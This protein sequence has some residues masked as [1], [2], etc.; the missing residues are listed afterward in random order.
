MNLF[1]DRPAL[2]SWNPSQAKQSLTIATLLN[3]AIRLVLVILAISA[4]SYWHL[5]SQLAE[6]T[7]AKLLGYITER[8]QREEEIFILAEDN[9]S[10]LQ[11][12]FLQGLNSSSSQERPQ[13]FH[14]IFS[15]WRDGTTRNVVEGTNENEFNTEYYPTSFI[16][17]DV[18]LTLDLQQRMVLSYELVEKYGAGW[19]NRFL[20]TYISLPEGANTVLWPG[21]AWGINAD[22]NLDIPAEEWAYLGDRIHNPK[23]QTLWTGVYADPVTQDFMVSAETPIDD[24]RGRHLATIGHDI[25]LT[26]LLERTIADRLPGTYNIIIRAD[27]QLIAEPQLMD[28]IQ[29]EGGKLKVETAGNAHLQRV[30]ELALESQQNDRVAYNKTDREY[31]AIAHL[32]G[33]NW[34]LITV[35]PESLLRSKAL[36][37]S[38]FVLALGFVSLL[39]EVSLLFVVLRHDIARPLQN[40]LSATQ[41]LATG[42]FQVELDTE[43][44]DELGQLARSFTEM[45]HQLQESFQTLEQRV[46][47][48]TT[49]LAEAKQSAESANRAKSDFLAKMSHELRT[50]LNGVLGYAQILERSNTLGEKERHEVNT[51]YDCGFHLLTLINDILDLSK[52]E[53]GKLQLVPAPVHLPSLLRSTVEMSDIQ[54]RQKGIDFVYAPDSNLPEGAIADEKRLRQVLLNLLGNAI[55]FTERGSVTLR[56]EAISARENHASIRFQVI[57]TGVGI[58]SDDLDKLFQA[59]EQV[60]DRQKQLEGTGLGLVISQQIVQLM[61]GMIAVTSQLGIGTECSFTIELPLS[62]DWKTDWQ[63]RSQGQSQRIVGYTGDRRKI[64]VVDDRPENRAVIVDLLEALDFIAIE[65]ENGRTG[66]EKLRSTQPDLTITDLAMPVMDGYQLLE[67]IRSDRDL[68]DAKVIV[69]SASVSPIDRQRSLDCG[70]NDFLPK[71]IDAKLLLNQLSLHLNLQWI[72]ESVSQ[73][74]SLVEPE[75]TALVLPPSKTLE[76]LLELAG[77]DNIKGLREHLVELVE[78][79][80][81]FSPFAEP[82]LQLAKQFETEEIEELLECHL[83]QQYLAE[84]RNYEESG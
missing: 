68:Q 49:E 66:L 20:D 54:A 79:D 34:Y 30:F 48:R 12:D 77:R 44:Q 32:Q 4:I 2:R 33:P 39:V 67:Y 13:P 11:Q 18:D 10:L 72:E 60:G 31:L 8:G 43:R 46:E 55:K 47:Q 81:A 71:P 65:A 15:T 35:Y 64:L 16:G 37:L 45:S 70:S 62:Q 21:A 82:L 23:R 24:D 80:R 69:S 9:H 75:P 52:I 61:G 26:N 51:I 41:Q 63:T 14:R 29:A 57:D 38:Q 78:S 56:V 1:T 84:E 36:E 22:S 76:S 17:K 3:M 74:S 59:F 27:G 42:N 40:L 58:A 50:P 83:L 7:E 53:A 6:D 73:E 28:R 25:I 5:M 19:R